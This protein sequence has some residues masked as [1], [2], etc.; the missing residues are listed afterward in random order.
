V[1]LGVAFSLATQLHTTALIVLP[2]VAIGAVLVLRSKLYFQKILL[3]AAVAFALYVPYFVYDAL[4]GFANFARLFVLGAHNLQG[5]NAA[6]SARALWNFFFGTLTP[7]N[8]WYTY[9][10]IE[11]N[12]LNVVVAA[13]FTVVLVLLLRNVFVRKLV[14]LNPKRLLYSGEGKAIVWLWL[15]VSAVV[16]L[17]YS[18]AAH[19][20]YLIVLWPVPLI[21]LVWVVWWLRLRFGVFRSVV[22]A[23][24]VVSALQI[25]SFYGHGRE[26]WKDFFSTYNARYKNDPNISEIGATW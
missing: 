26:P 25:V 5:G 23:L 4:H 3:S 14:A 24:V 20:H 15:A 8:Y 13:V 11:P 1:W 12:S 2:L 6:F 21:A 16:L 9:T 18:R 22:F 19:D 7:F 17:L 10:N